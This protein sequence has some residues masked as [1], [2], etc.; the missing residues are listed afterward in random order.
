MTDTNQLDFNSEEYFI[1]TRCKDDSPTYFDLARIT[2]EAF[3][4]T[5]L[6]V[7]CGLGWLVRHL[8]KRRIEASG[9]DTSQYAIDHS[10]SK[11]HCFLESIDKIVRTFPNQFDTVIMKDVGQVFELEGLVRVAEF[12]KTICRGRLLFCDSLKGEGFRRDIQW[13]CTLFQKCGWS[14]SKLQPFFRNVPSVGD[15]LVLELPRVPFTLEPPSSFVDPWLVHHDHTVVVTSTLYTSDLESQAFSDYHRDL[16]MIP[17]F[18]KDDGTRFTRERLGVTRSCGDYVFISDDTARISKE[19]LFSALASFRDPS[20][21]VVFSPVNWLGGN[22][23]SPVGDYWDRFPVMFRVLAYQQSQGLKGKF[24]ELGWKVAKIKTPLTSSPYDENSDF[25][26]TPFVTIITPFDDSKI[27]ILPK[28]IEAFSSV[29][30]PRNCL[31]VHF[32]DDSRESSANKGILDF[33]KSSGD[34]FASISFF[35][36]RTE[37]YWLYMEGKEYY[38]WPGVTYPISCRVAGLYNRA[39]SFIRTDRILLWESDTIPVSPDFLQV[40]SAEIGDCSGI[41]GHYVCRKENK[42]LAWDLPSLVPLSW[43]WL[44]P[45][46]GVQVVGAV[47]HGLLLL[48]S[49]CLE[50]FRFGVLANDPRDFRGPDLI[51]GRDF[52]G[53]GL[54]LKIHWDVHALHYESDGET[55]FKPGG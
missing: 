36:A 2:V 22:E 24:D 8:R 3:N 21:G 1:S 53:L 25:R 11:E 55:F 32:W 43:E 17:H 54:K 12:L 45:G 28:Y 35:H 26:I 41:S 15:I 13:Y 10:V 14:V 19:W 5:V 18:V 20:V 16:W 44:E 27:K 30:Y 52:K 23:E 31:H 49:N 7:G 47:P 38:R 29:Q 34:K 48:D 50:K 37:D 33:I 40:L 46:S 42:S 4:G 9:I 39:T 51:M 6:D